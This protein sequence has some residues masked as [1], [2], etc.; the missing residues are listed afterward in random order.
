MEKSDLKELKK[1]I[2]SKD[3]VVDWVYGLYVDSENNPVY[4]HVGKLMDFDEAEQFRH[5]GIFNRVLSSKVGQ[6]TYP[7]PLGSHQE[8]LLELRA[9]GGVSEEEFEVFREALLGGYVHTDPYYATLAR[10]I[11]DV[12]SKSKDGRR[13]EDGDQVYEAL[14]FSV[15]PAKLTRP[16]LGFEEDHVAELS[17]RWQIGNPACGF[18][19][20]AFSDRM[21]DRGEVLIFSKNPNTEDF[22]NG[23]FLIDAEAAPVGVKEQKFLFSDL[24][25][26]MDMNLE[27]A[28][29][30]SE[31]ILEKSAEEDVPLMLEKEAVRAIA[32]GAGVDTQEFDEIY[33]E[34][35]GETPIALP[36]VAEP[37]VTV[38]TDRVTLKVP[39]SASQLIETRTIDGRDYILIPADGTVTVNGT[40]VTVGTVSATG[41]GTGG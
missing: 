12:P 1:V 15:C 30:I 2:K 11:Y 17:R 23:M 9:A 26:Q 40:A 27:A 37:Y 24:L 5:V 31:G 38:R 41:T 19:Y 3:T 28:A 33:E 10:I 4:E 34:T 29:A 35:I 14:L 21:E 25:T 20:P 32:E 6:D 16:A 39:S 36:S 13:L 22:I 8:A 7:V 18:L